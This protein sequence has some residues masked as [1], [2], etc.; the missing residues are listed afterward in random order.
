V[1]EA[2]NIPINNYTTSQFNEQL[3]RGN[4]NPQQ[5]CTGQQYQSQLHNHASIREQYIQQEQQQ[6][7][8]QATSNK[9]Q[10]PPPSDDIEHCIDVDFETEPLDTV[11]GLQNFNPGK[12]NDDEDSVFPAQDCEEP[13]R[14]D[15]NLTGQYED[16]CLLP[17]MFLDAT[18]MYNAIKD[19]VP[20]KERKP[21]VRPRGELSYTAV[22]LT[23]LLIKL[24][25]RNGGSKKCLM[26]YWNSF[27]NGRR[28]TK[29]YST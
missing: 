15:N 21:T 10:K 2:V 26:M 20:P 22:A 18:D 8:Q 28:L 5:F 13:N 9:Q 3:A 11:I 12:E 4:I 25:N 17:T 6:Q 16:E 1:E 29:I 14:S 24:I 19:I 27:L 23:Q 7:Q